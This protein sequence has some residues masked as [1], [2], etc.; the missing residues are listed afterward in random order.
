MYKMCVF[1]CVIVVVCLFVLFYLCVCLCYFTC[2]FV[3]LLFDALKR[4]TKHIHKQYTHAFKT[5]P[6]PPS[7]LSFSFPSPFYISLLY[8]LLKDLYK[9]GKWLKVKGG[10]GREGEVKGGGVKVLQIGFPCY[11]VCSISPILPPSSLPF[12]QPLFSH[13]KPSPFPFLIP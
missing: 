13:E 6:F 4:C 7:F 8:F 12:P 10:R 2:V 1:V 5:F 9:L 11:L 3:Y